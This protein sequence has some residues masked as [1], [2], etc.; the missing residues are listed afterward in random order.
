MHLSDECICLQAALT[1]HDLDILQRRCN[2]LKSMQFLVQRNCSIKPRD[3]LS[4]DGET[5]T[6]QES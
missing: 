5:N 1:D 3:E 2:L 4:T 6:S